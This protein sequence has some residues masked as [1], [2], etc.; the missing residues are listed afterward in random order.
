MKSVLQHVDKTDDGWLIVHPKD[1]A[2]LVYSKSKKQLKLH[3]RIYSATDSSD[4]PWKKGLY[5][6]EI[7]NSPHRGGLNYKQAK[8]GRTWFRIGHSGDRYIHTGRHSLGCITLIEQGKWDELCE[9]LLK[10][11]K[12]DGRGVGVLEI[13]D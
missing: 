8:Y 4:A 7:P 9:N 6:I 10:A 1:S 12:G 3:D 11:R 2:F 5:D 13:V